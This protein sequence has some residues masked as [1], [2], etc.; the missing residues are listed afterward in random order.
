MWLETITLRPDR[1]HPRMSVIVLRRA[2]GSIPDSGSS[3]MS[4]SGS[5]ASA[6]AIFTRCRIPLL[7]APIFLCAALDRSTISSARFAASMAAVS[8]PPFNLTSAVTHS[9][10][11]IRS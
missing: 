10:P 6:C 3:R 5:C 4:S 8:L 9:S 2:I 7:Y 11:V 1:P